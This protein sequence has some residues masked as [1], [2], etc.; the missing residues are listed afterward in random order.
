LDQFTVRKDGESEVMTNCKKLLK[1]EDVKYIKVRR[2]KW[3]RHL[4]RMEDIKLVKKITDWNPIG[5]RT[6]GLPKNKR[7][8]E[9]INDLKKRKLRN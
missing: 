6:E 8:D 4:N 7:R 9:T 2:I 5:I 1:G 3:R